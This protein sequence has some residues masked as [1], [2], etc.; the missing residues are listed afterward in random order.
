MTQDERLRAAVIQEEAI[1]IERIRD[2]CETYQR[3]GATYRH[4]VELIEDV[5]DAQARIV[6]V[7]NKVHTPE[8]K[9]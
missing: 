6:R 5:I 9:A 3:G 4:V 7:G 2:A 1:V 8:V